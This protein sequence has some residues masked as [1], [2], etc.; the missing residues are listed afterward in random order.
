MSTPVETGV[1]VV[2]LGSNIGARIDGVR[3]G[4]DLSPEAVAEIR[5]ALLANKVIFFRGQD[6][7]DDDGQLAFG[8]LLGEVTLAHPTVRGVQNPNILPIDSEYGKANSWHTDVTFVDRV[9]AV[10]ILR[11][12]HLPP[13]GG[14]TV[15]ANTVAAYESLPL[16][17]KALVDGLWAVHTNSYDY[18]ANIDEL[19][20]GGVDVK[21]EQYRKEFQSDLY[22]T[23][24]PV[25]RVHPET[26]ERSLLLGHFVKRLIGVTSTESQALFQ[27]LQQ[28]VTR[29]ENTVRWQWQHGDVAIWDNRATQHYAIADYDDQARRLHRITLAGDV[30]VSIDGTPSV[31]RTG[32]ASHYSAAL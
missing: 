28:R 9:P 22:E 19:R 1:S 21:T 5:A 13:Y 32:D 20:I 10:S 26:G 24:H 12:V 3:L 25:V 14:N 11:A 4:G 31:V 15:W 17:L 30:P 2:K 8:G 23:E 7:L 6:H 27:L 16:S 29:L 18:A